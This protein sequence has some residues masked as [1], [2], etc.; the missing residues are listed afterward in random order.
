MR[1]TLHTLVTGYA[2]VTGC[3]CEAEEG[4]CQA[5]L[6]VEG[7]AV[8]IGLVENSGMIVLQTGVGLL[9]QQGREEFCLW[10]LAANNLFSETMGFT[11]G[12]DAGQELVTVQLAWDLSHLDAEGFARLVHNVLSVAADWMLRVDAW[13]PSAPGEEGEVSEEKAAAQPYMNFLQI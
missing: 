7:L 1:K 12:V 2:A 11:L 13:R 10:L 4:S 9:P 8:Q 6:L 5:V 3:S